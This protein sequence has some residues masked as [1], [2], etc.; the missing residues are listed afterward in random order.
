MIVGNCR[1]LADFGKNNVHRKNIQHEAAKREKSG[2]QTT[3]NVNADY[4][5]NSNS[6]PWP[7][8]HREVL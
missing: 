6:L 3:K 8:C 5:Q 7:P 1:F 4:H 2:M